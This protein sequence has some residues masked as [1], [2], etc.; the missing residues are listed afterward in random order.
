[1]AKT[2]AAILYVRSGDGG[3]CAKPPH[4]EFQLFDYTTSPAEE[5]TIIGADHMDFED[6]L[7]SVDWG[8]L[9]FCPRGRADAQQ[10][11]NITMR[12]MIPWYNVY[13]KGETE[14][15]DFYD[16]VSS[17]DDVSHGLVTIRRNFQK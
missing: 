12:Y 15:S 4:G 10:V 5:L 16:G 17:A 11:R 8:G 1:L 6:S 7:V 9:L 13:L 14:F 2:D 3:Y